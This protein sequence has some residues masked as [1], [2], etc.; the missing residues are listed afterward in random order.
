ML[1]FFIEIEVVIW[2]T[3]CFVED[4]VS[5]RFACSTCTTSSVNKGVD[6]VQTLLDDN[7]NIVNVETSCCYVCCY[8]Y[9]V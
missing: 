6:I 2:S 8:Q 3:I 1:K 4:Y 7:V 5:S 9:S